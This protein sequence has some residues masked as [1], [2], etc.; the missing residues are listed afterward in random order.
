MELEEDTE[1]NNDG[2]RGRSFTSNKTK[3]IVGP[4]HQTQFVPKFCSIVSKVG[5]TNIIL[6]HT[7][8]P[9]GRCVENLQSVK[10]SFFTDS[11]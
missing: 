2:G 1:H 6:R 3:K 10:T 7:S 4:K 8:S 9:T 11:A 5:Q